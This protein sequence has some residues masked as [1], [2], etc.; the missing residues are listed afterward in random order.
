VIFR[1][2]IQPWHPSSTLTAEAS[3]SFTFVF[4]LF[5]DESVVEKSR[6]EQYKELA[7]LVE[8]VTDNT[9][10]P[11]AVYGLLEIVSVEHPGR[12][13]NAGNILINS[14]KYFIKLGRQN[15][16]HVSPTALWDGLVE[17]SISSGWSLEDW[18]T[19]FRNR[20]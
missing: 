12:A 11:E 5:F 4:V 17:N 19:F 16:I 2:Q 13:A 9:L 1:H 10:K 14:L 3:D 20:L 18:Q 7:A 15:G 6:K 8:S